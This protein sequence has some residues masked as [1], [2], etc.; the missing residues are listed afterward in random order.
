M[1]TLRNKVNLIGNLGMNPE[2][3]TIEGGTKVARVSIA[4]NETYRNQKGEKISETQWH[5]L[6]AW[7]KTAEIFEK[8]TKAGSKVVVEG[9]L[10]N[11]QYTDKSGQ[12]RFITEVL[13]NEIMILAGFAKDKE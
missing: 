7:G 5:N 11:R 13:I 8:Y 4:T 3:R 12:K 2:V 1:K 10:V 6:V 9:K